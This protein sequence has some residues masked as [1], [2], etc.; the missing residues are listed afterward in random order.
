MAELFASRS[1]VNA[2]LLKGTKFRKPD[3]TFDKQY[4]LDLGGVKAT[5][6]ALGPTHTRGDTAIWV[7]DGKEGVIFAGDIVMNRTILAYGEYSSTKAW[8]EALAQLAKLR[9]QEEEDPAVL[10]PSHGPIGDADL[11]AYQRGFFQAVQ[12]RVKQMKDDG[13]SGEEIVKAVTEEFKDRYKMWK[14]TDR[15]ESIVRNVYKE[16]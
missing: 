16:M 5:F 7:Q 12:A 11:I 2:D 15:I 14:A 8:M 6:M 13:K 9:P 3:I 1:P 10:V 4:E